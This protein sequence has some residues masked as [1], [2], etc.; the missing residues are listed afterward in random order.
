MESLPYW[1][2]ALLLAVVALVVFLTIFVWRWAVRHPQRAAQGAVRVSGETEANI[3]SA[4][5]YVAIGASDVAGVGAGDPQ[6]ENWASVLHSFMPEDTRLLRLARPGITLR[7]AN[8]REIFEAVRAQPDQITLWCCVND[9]TNGVPLPDYT[10]ELEIALTRLTRE[11]HARVLVLNVPDMSR[12]LPPSASEA[13]R[14]LIRGGIQQW[15]RAITTTIA[16]YGS[17]VALLDLFNVSEETMSRQEN[18]ASDGIHLSAAGHRALALL[19]WEA[20]RGTQ[21]E[22]C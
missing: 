2:A 21:Y 19:A 22:S 1:A 14:A 11:T 4:P 18:I 6:R 8:A 10:R 17:R 15:N 20:I 12:L 7:E 3:E 5:L 9:I 13:Q 16:R